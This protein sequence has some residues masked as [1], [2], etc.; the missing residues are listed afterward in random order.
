MNDTVNYAAAVS[1][2]AKWLDIQEPDWFGS[3]VTSILNMHD[4]YYCVYGQVFGDFYNF[5]LNNLTYRDMFNMGFT[6][7]PE[8]VYYNDE[9][10]GR[11]HYSSDNPDWDILRDFWI[12]EI[13]ARS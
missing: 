12:S 13:Q 2:G 4:Y 8:N 1:K 3:V 11:T 7:V 9:A 10:P 6:I 5:D